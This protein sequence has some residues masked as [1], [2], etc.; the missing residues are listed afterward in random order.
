MS[1]AISRTDRQYE[2]ETGET[3]P[4]GHHAVQLIMKYGA[5]GEVL[6]YQWTT[7]DDETLWPK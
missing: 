5:Q 3:I 4:E 7:T 6:M 1:A 2:E